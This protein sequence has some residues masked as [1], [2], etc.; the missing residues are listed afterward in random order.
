MTGYEYRKKISCFWLARIIRELYKRSR[1][2]LEK[3]GFINT[4]AIIVAKQ[5]FPHALGHLIVI[6]R[7]IQCYVEVYELFGLGRD[8]HY[9]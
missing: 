5:S 6:I 9:L 2:S 7:H 1:W 8:T 4:Q 3:Q